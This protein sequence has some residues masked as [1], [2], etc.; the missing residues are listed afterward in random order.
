MAKLSAA[1]NFRYQVTTGPSRIVASTERKAAR[2]SFKMRN[3]LKSGDKK[4]KPI[5]ASTGRRALNLVVSVGTTI[6]N[7]IKDFKI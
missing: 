1:D 6:K 4:P 2:A 7:E 3:L 5:G